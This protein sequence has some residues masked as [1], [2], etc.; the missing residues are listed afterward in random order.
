VTASPHGMVP[1]IDVVTTEAMPVHLSNPVKL[2]VISANFLLYVP[3]LM[4]V[5]CKR[6]VC[7]E[8]VDP[9]LG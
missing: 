6:F 7:T 5:H 4:V 2:F 8:N 9:V 3:V 1:D